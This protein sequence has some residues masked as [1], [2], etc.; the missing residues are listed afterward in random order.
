MWF[1]SKACKPVENNQELQDAEGSRSHDSLIF[2]AVN[3]TFSD[4][5][6]GSWEGL[7]GALLKGSSTFYQLI[8][9]CTLFRFYL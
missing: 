2:P 4:S 8:I 6:D 5:T 9:T 1:E 7:W 3:Y